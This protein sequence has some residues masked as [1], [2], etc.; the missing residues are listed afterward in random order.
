MFRLLIYV[1]LV[2][3]LSVLATVTFYSRQLAEKERLEMSGQV[4]RLH[5]QT[6]QRLKQ[7]FAELDGIARSIGGD[8]YVQRLADASLTRDSAEER[9]LRDYTDMLIKQQISQMPYISDLCVAV[10][11]KRYIICTNSD[12]AGALLDVQPGALQKQ[13]RVIVRRQAEDDVS[14]PAEMIYAAPVADRKTNVVRGSVHMMIDMDS[15]MK[16][17]YGKWPL[18]RN[19]LLDQDGATMYSRFSSAYNGDVREPEWATA[20]DGQTQ[21]KGDAVWSQLKVELPGTVW[22]SRIEAPQSLEHAHGQAFRQ[23]L[24]LA[25]LLL[26]FVIGLSAYL[27]RHF[28]TTPM[29]HLRALMNRAEL[30]DFKAYWVRKSSR[31]WSELGESYNQMLNRL[32]ELIKQVKR[33]ESLKKEAEMEALQYQLNPHFLYNTLNTIKWVAKMHHTPQIAEVVTSL[34]R[35][36]QASLGKKGD[37]ITIREEIGLIRDYMEIQSF[38]Y[39]D[40]VRLECEVDSLTNGCLVPRMILQ[41]LVE[42]AIIHGIE[43]GRKGGLIVIRIWLDVQRELL[44]CQV[45]DNGIGMESEPLRHDSDAAAMRER[46]SGIG[47]KHI[48]EKIRLYYGDGY[49]MSIISKARQG[50]TIRLTLPVHQ[51]E[52]G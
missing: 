48:R 8:P 38:R 20:Q 3:T 2:C 27:F 23:T 51:S 36:L 12:A 6:L 24:A 47:L 31:E 10:N 32:E 18:L 14:G 30:G 13:D 44:L 40:Q 21:W 34:V 46:M 39:G 25:I 45:E 50:T 17:I 43:P 16:D 28:F 29:L 41:P 33:E 19:Q 9:T 15:L 52:V 37:F 49:N 4:A 5:E 7:T 1:L 35:L 42:N 22:T 11:D 26:L